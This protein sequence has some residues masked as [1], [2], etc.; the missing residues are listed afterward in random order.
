MTFRQFFSNLL[1]PGLL[2]NVYQ[3]CPVREFRI[4]VLR[5]GIE[6]MVPGL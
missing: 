6:R 3:E 2:E 1:D 4:P 5:D